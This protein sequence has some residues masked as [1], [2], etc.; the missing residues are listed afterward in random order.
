MGLLGDAAGHV[1]PLTGEGIAHALW[2]AE[3]LAKAFGQGD[4]QVYEGLWREQ[5]GR[6]LMAASGMLS[7]VDL[8]VS[9]Y[10]IV[11]QVAMAMALAVP[12]RVV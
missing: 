6:G 7:A 4:P 8:D 10:E 1:H 9:A 2:S 5:Y 12:N 11:F 3:L